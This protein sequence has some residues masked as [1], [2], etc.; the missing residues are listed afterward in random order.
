MAALRERNSVGSMISYDSTDRIGSRVT[1]CPVSKP[2]EKPSALK[3]M[4]LINNL[5]EIMNSFLKLG[6]GLLPQLE[7][8]FYF[9]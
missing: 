5:L 2:T 9:P 4:I 1:R 7:K 6:W 3:Y 8:D